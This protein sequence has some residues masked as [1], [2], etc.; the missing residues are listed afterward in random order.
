[1]CGAAGA[2]ITLLLTAQGSAAAESA[3]STGVIVHAGVSDAVKDSY[4]VVLK[5]GSVTAQGV[6]AAVATLAARYGVASASYTYRSA[7]PGFAASMSE[8]KASLLAGDPAVDFVEQDRVIRAATDQSWPPSWGLDRIDQETR[9]L[10]RQYSY[11]DQGASGVTAYIMDTGV[12]ITHQ[13]F[14][15][16]AVSGFDAIDGGTADDCNGHGTHAAGIV[17][18]TTFGVAKSVRLVAVRVLDCTGAGT[19]ASVVAGVDWVT[20]NA[21]LPAVV[22]MSFSGGASDAMDQAVTNSYNAGLAFSV[23]AGN[24]GGDACNYAPARIR[25]A[26]TV[27][28]IDQFDDLAPSS[29][30][31]PC[32][33]LVAPGVE[34]R[35]A[36]HLH[37]FQE[38]VA[39][40]TSMAA[41][42][43]TGAIALQLSLHPYYSGE[44]IN[45]NLWRTGSWWGNSDLRVVRIMHGAIRPISGGAGWCV[46][47]RGGGTAV[48]TPVQLYRCNGTPA[49]KW[50]FTGRKFFNPS[51]GKCLEVSGS[52]NHS[53]T[54]LAECTRTVAPPI[55]NQRWQRYENTLGFVNDVSARCLHSPE[56]R[57]GTQLEVIDCNGTGATVWSDPGE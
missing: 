53:V 24:N 1:V 33:D 54:R 3:A 4:I 35:S 57:N 18:G 56:Y 7:L 13:E 45:G 11:P 50:Y 8:K 55:G 52:A 46:D 49:Q 16:R 29:N 20:R 51:S 17:G 48:G 19:T 37:D 41:A 10:D 26:T 47:V 5:R 44:A 28:S 43:V 36:W 39:S 40:G 15:G 9:G 14:G 32:V 22:N 6:D 21:T 34:I 12:R 38:N 23:S 42:H 27:A 31:G 30:I 2:A 25:V